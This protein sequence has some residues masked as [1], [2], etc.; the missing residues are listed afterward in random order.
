MTTPTTCCG[1]TATS[2]TSDKQ[3][4][5]TT[6]RQHYGAVATRVLANNTTGCCDSAC[7][8]SADDSSITQ[9]LYLADQLEGLPLKAALASLGCGNPTA[10]AELRP[11][12]VVLDLGSG[13][14]LM[15]S[16]RPGVP[17]PAASPMGWI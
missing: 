7:C 1:P 16:S 14:G 4:F 15:C 6:V 9:N 12:E 17:A 13:A 5:L 8:G 3:N 10:L 2:T 11:G